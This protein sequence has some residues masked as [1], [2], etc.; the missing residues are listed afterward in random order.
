MID[1]EKVVVEGEEAPSET[2]VTE[3]PAPEAS[4]EAEDKAEA[5]E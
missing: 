2:P 3:T 5:T 4:E 1:E